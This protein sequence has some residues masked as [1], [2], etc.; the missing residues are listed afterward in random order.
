MHFGT[1]LLL[2]I[3][4]PLL[5]MG[6]IGGSLYVQ[7]DAENGRS[8]LA[9]GVIIAATCGASMIYQVPNWSLFQQTVVHFSIMLVTV[10]PAMLLSGWFDLSVAT[11]WLMAAG[12]FL[13]TGIVLWTVFF[14]V[15]KFIE[16]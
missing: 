8:T 4:I 1:K 5:I 15:F 16:Q 10:L 14:T 13:L 7:G 6:S 2:L 11:G 12:L 3:G 9:V